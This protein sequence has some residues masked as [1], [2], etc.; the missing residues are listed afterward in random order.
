MVQH[1]NGVIVQ[2]DVDGDRLAELDIHLFGISTISS[3][4]FDL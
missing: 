1:S 3:N 2:A 4:D